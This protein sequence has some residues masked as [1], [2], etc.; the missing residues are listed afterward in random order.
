MKLSRKRRKELIAQQLSIACNGKQNNLS[1]AHLD[2]TITVSEKE[3]T[4]LVLLP[5]DHPDVKSGTTEVRETLSNIPIVVAAII[6]E[7]RRK[8]SGTM[9]SG[10]L[11][12]AQLEACG[13][14]IGNYRLCKDEML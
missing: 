5:A 8:I 9:S 10:S 7:P 11:P 2:N 3:P 4:S 14:M 1:V 13:C 12:L 6:P